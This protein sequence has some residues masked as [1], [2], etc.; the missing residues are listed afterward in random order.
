MPVRGRFRGYALV[1]VSG[2]GRL[3]SGQR[4]RGFDH[5][6]PWKEIG[7]G[8]HRAGQCQCNRDRTNGSGSTAGRGPG[9]SSRGGDFSEVGVTAGTA[10]PTTFTANETCAA[11][12]TT[13][14]AIDTCTATPIAG[15]AN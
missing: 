5:D 9:R 10:T 1:H 2:P 4:M 15:R 6:C 3:C 11:T 14:T 13:G 7:D 12:P 8:Q